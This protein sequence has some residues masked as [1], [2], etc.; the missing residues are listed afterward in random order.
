VGGR[1]FVLHADGDALRL[2]YRALGFI[3][4]PVPGRSF[5]LARISLESLGGENALVANIGNRRALVATRLEPVK[6]SPAW[7]ARIGTYEVA[8]AD[9][10]DLRIDH[11]RIERQGEFLL[12]KLRIPDVSEEFV[13]ARALLPLDDRRAVVAGV[14][15]GMGEVLRAV[16]TPDGERLRYLGLLLTRGE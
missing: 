8:N 3:P 10:R 16:E 12:F 13:T 14:G 9:E 5:R 11:V 6:L 1:T 7:L 4:M 2:G 15:Q